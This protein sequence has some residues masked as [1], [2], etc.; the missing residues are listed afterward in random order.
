LPKS[1]GDQSYSVESIDGDIMVTTITSHQSV[2]NATD[3]IKFIARR[4]NDIDLLVNGV[5]IGKQRERN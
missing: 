3:L 2:N 4:V 1:E 5:S